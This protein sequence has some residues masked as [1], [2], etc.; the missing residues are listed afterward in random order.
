MAN[1]YLL[2]DEERRRAALA[3]T[4]VL[5]EELP[6]PS[7]LE[8]EPEAGLP[9]PEVA[10]APELSAPPLVEAEEEDPKAALVRDIL[11]RRAGA[12]LEVAAPVAK[13][14]SKSLLPGL[15]SDAFSSAMLHAA[16][17]KIPPNP[18][19]SDP[20]L[21]LKKQLYEAKIRNAQVGPS[22][23]PVDEEMRQAILR[24]K[25]ASAGLAE[26]NTA[27]VPGRLGVSEGGLDLRIRQALEKAA[28]D[29]RDFEAKEKHLATNEALA[30]DKF[31]NGKDQFITSK[32]QEMGHRTQKLAPVVN[33]LQAINGKLPPGGI[34]KFLQDVNQGLA[35]RIT[36]EADAQYR[37][38]WNQVTSS[39]RN[40]LYGAALTDN[41]LKEADKLFGAGMSYSPE[42][43]ARGIDLVRGATHR[44]LA[45]YQSRLASEYPEDF[46]WYK[47]DTRDTTF[48]NPVFADLNQEGGPA[49]AAPPL[50]DEQIVQEVGTEGLEALKS[51][52]PT[53][54]RVPPPAKAKPAA[55]PAAQ[56][57]TVEVNGV[58]WELQ[59]NGKYKARK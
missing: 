20:L 22:G 25:L 35:G 41:E 45:S 32:I 1:P 55:A 36:P 19:A 42:A 34:T 31:A 56:P 17:R 26:A 49:S 16:Y 14:E 13:E 48:Q 2:D 30:A 54:I 44:Q 24:Q 23:K 47:N 52:V 37:Q 57:Q 50:P 10:E 11:K 43:L 4:G 18:A 40:G 59:P 27:A 5:P 33:G 39:Y 53:T 12:D 21:A 51:D 15:G 46:T 7:P 58:T 9:E 8:E 29:K 38:A 3:E 28:K 6:L